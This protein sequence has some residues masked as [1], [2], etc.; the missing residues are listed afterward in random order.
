MTNNN[1]E[2]GHEKRRENIASA[3]QSGGFMFFSTVKKFR[4]GEFVISF[5]VRDA[6]F[7]RI[8]HITACSTI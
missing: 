8:L 2:I 3:S 4:F 1:E 7:Q 5:W 6:F